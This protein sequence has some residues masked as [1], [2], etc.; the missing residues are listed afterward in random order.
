MKNQLTDNYQKEAEIFKALSHP[1]RLFIL[2]KIRNET[3]SVSELAAMIEVDIST[4][5]KHLDL[6]KRY[7][8]IVGEKNKNNIYYKLNITCLF[9]FLDCAKKLSSCPSEATCQCL[10]C[11]PK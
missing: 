5:S 9:T 1:T 7:Q 8:I 11:L 2:D 4:M 3:F 6:L 10:D